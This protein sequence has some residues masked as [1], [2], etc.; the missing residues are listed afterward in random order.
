MRWDR[1][2]AVRSLLLVLLGLGALCSAA[3][4][5]STITGLATAGG[6]CLLL[7]YLT[8]PAGGGRA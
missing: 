5:Y 7:A 6:A 4:L 1:L 2:T 3:L 8:D